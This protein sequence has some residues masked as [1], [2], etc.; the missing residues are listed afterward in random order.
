MTIF[1]VVLGTPGIHVNLEIKFGLGSPQARMTERKGNG[2]NNN[3]EN[4]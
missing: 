3:Y 2:K 1:Y 4:T